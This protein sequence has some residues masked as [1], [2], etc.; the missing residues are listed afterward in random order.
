MAPLRGSIY[1]GVL[2]G[3]G[4]VHAST[5]RVSIIQ[6]LAVMSK[7]VASFALF[8]CF[9]TGCTST[10][11]NQITKNAFMAD[12]AVSAEIV[13]KPTS[14]R[15]EVRPGE[16]FV[17][18][19]PKRE[20][21]RPDY[22][23]SLLAKQLYPVSVIARIVVNAAGEVEKA[24]IVESSATIPEFSESVLAAVR[25]WTFIPLKRVIGR[26]IEP[27]PFTQ[28]YRFTFKQE[29]GR[30]VVIQGSPDDS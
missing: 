2:H 30:A 12:G 13:Y 10:P 15:Y 20:N 29:N 27:L 9:V 17:R 26:E 18:E 1:C 5:L 11:E 24:R 14:E 22:P 23:A 25:T 4:G 28:E 21:A 7:I 16:Q 3:L 19:L 6:V 8:T